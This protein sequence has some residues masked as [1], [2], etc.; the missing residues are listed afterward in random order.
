MCPR[1][2]RN[3][4]QKQGRQA[5]HAARKYRPRA[6]GK[7]K[8]VCHRGKRPLHLMFI[9][10]GHKCSRFSLYVQV[11]DLFSCGRRVGF[12]YLTHTHKHQYY[13]N[14]RPKTTTAPKSMERGNGH[15]SGITANQP[16][17]Y[18]GTPGVLAKTG[19]TDPSG[20]A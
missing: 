18:G 7:H 3:R 17:P 6:C 9:R 11:E 8:R 15:F 19:C 2:R 4:P 16:G 5:M 14:A 1:M 20:Q 12:Q 13:E 10:N